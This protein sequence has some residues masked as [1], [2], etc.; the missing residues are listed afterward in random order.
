MTIL[1]DFLCIYFVKYF[2]KG[3]FNVFILFTKC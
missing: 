1:P 2:L 3:G